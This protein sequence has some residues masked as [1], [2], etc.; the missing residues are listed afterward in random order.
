MDAGVTGKIEEVLQLAAR[1]GRRQLLEGE[2]YALLGHVGIPTPR[3]VTVPAGA[4]REETAHAAAQLLGSAGGAKPSGIVVK[5]Q[6]PQILHKTEAGGIAFASADAGAVADAAA[7]VL[8]RVRSRVPEAELTGVLLSEKIDYPANLPGFEVLLSMRQDT[9][10][11]PIIVFGIGGL[12]T[13]WFGT[14]APNQTTCVLSAHDPILESKDLPSCLLR[15]PAFSLLFEPSRL[16]K[17]P[18]LDRVEFWSLLRRWA[19]LARTFGSDHEG[20]R[21]VIE[22]LEINPMAV[23]IASGSVLPVAIDGIGRIGVRPSGPR[24]RRVEKVRNLLEPRSVA[25]VGA[26]GRSMNAGRIILQNLRTAEGVAY[27][28]IYGVHPKEKSIDSIP[29]VASVRDLPERVDLAVVCVPADAARDAVRDIVRERKAHAIILIPGGFAETGSHGLANEIIAHLEEGRG[30]EDGGPVLV[31]GNCLGIVSKR[32]YNTFF[33]PQYKLPFN[34]APGDNLVAISQSGAYLVTLTSNLDGV[35][36]P[37]ASISYGNQMDL[38]VS[39]FL[40]YYLDDAGVQVVVCYI[41]GFQPLD[42]LRCVRAIRE[43]RARG[44]S[45]IVF[46]AGKTALGAQAAASHTASLAGDYAVARTMLTDAGAIVAETLNQFE[47]FTKVFTMLYDRIPFGRSVGI[48]SNAGFEC[49]AAMDAL[50]DLE[51]ARFTDAT[52]ARLRECLPGIAHA[53]NAVDATPMATTRQFIQAVEAILDDPQVDALVV[54]AVP[55]TQALDDLPPDPDGRHPEN[56]YSLSSLPQELIR[57]FRGSAKP[58]VVAVDSGRI[59]DDCVRLLQRGGVP[60][61]RKIDRATRALSRYCTSRT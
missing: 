44:R 36:Y 21:A 56:I 19:D 50:Y 27:G 13:E 16:H 29:C 2:V 20:D 38:T 18:P 6:S 40:N 53:D 30:Q 46:K 32:Q 37:K 58:F 60:V 9:A 59:Y 26:S 3:Y 54:S 10:M 25:V 28:H 7:Q 23:P 24:R 22:E 55:V 47:D 57:V 39:D 8:D 17:R 45:V 49:S 52:K 41:E 43:H 61:F 33:L 34:D 1:D 42:G 5:I 11:G 14:L 48:I 15:G 51:F 4:S 35:I 31:G 12:L